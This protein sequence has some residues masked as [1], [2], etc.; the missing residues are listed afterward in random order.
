MTQETGISWQQQCRIFGEVLQQA[1]I[2]DAGGNELGPERGLDDWVAQTRQ[3]RTRRGRLFLAGNGA[4]ASMASHFATDLAKNAGIRTQVFT[5]LS[6]MTALGNDI[7]YEAVFAEPLRWYAETGD[8]LVAISSSGNSPNIVQAVL[9]AKELGLTVITLSGMRPD[10]RIRALGDLNLYLA[11][12]TYGLAESGH[13]FLLHCWMD[14]L[15][16]AKDAAGVANGPPA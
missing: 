13:A 15:E 4:S 7:A 10:N 12:P 11:A 1:S 3:L 9:A 2:R 8:M 5:D 14:R 6:L 16:L